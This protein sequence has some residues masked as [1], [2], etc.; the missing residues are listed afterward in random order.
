[1]LILFQSY[2]HHIFLFKLITSIHYS[3]CGVFVNKVGIQ[4]FLV[5][6]RDQQKLR[7][8]Y[9]FEVMIIQSDHLLSSAFIGFTFP[10]P[11]KQLVVS[12]QVK[13]CSP[14]SALHLS[15]DKPD[16]YPVTAIHLQ[17]LQYPVSIKTFRP[18]NSVLAK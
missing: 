14:K 2:L 9:Q 1:M 13:A 18:S 3:V 10:I 7:K 11:L 15:I 8:N 5:L 16:A 17:L 6:H 4:T 12:H